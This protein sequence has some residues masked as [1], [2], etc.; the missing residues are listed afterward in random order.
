MGSDRPDLKLLTARTIKWNTIDRVSSQ[1]LYAAVG[2]VLANI[3]TQTE[4][5]L[6]GALAIFQAFAI[7]FVDSG[8][9]AALLRDKNPTQEDYSTVFWFNTGVSVAVYL[10]L[11]ICA[12]GIAK[13]FQDQ[14][15]LI[16]MSK[17]MF[18]TFVI[19]GLAIV[20]T[21]RLMK[22]MDVKMIAVSNTL[23]LI[24]GGVAGI[25]LALTGA[26]AWAMVWQ[27]VVMASVKTSTLWLTG[28]WRPSL[29]FSSRSLKKIRAV[30]F[31]VFSSAL[32]NTISLNLY[33][34]VIGVHYGM[35]PLGQYGQADKWAKMGSTSISQILTSSFVPLMAEAQDSVDRFR[36]YARRTT[37]FTACLLFPLMGMMCIEADGIFHLLFANLWDAAIPMFRI[38]CLRGVFVVIIGLYSNYLLA[39]GASRGLFA[40]EF[41]KD[42]LL[43]LSL[44]TLLFTPRIDVL[45]WGLLGASAL[46]WAVLVPLTARK[47]GLRVTEMLNSLL[48]FILLTAVVCLAMWGLHCFPLPAMEIRAEALLRLA[49]DI[50]AGT[51]LY[52]GLLSIMKFEE[53]R[54]ART[55]FLGRFLRQRSY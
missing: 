18:L 11:C 29:C 54:D 23:G 48:P 49:I 4:F 46:T 43:F 47:A 51:G 36:R 20:Q 33:N 52:L 55:Y 12:P 27:N 22:R 10:L 13:A 14:P 35:A 7:I 5:G 16:P 21:N 44:G 39:R 37:R 34:I 40:S 31:S 50:T 3:L 45:I 8:F 41:I 6:V 2:V 30:G 24:A 28:G 9:G 26:G 38:L 19:N 17:V 25:W 15:A 32:L 53:W 1:V 42:G